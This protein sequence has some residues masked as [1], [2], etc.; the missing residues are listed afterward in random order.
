MAFKSG[1]I[2][3]RFYN[4]LGL[5]FILIFFGSAGFVY[6]AD[7]G[8]VNALYMTVITISTVGFKEVEP[9]DAESKIFTIFLIITSITLFGYI[10]SVITDY[11]ANNKFIEELKFKQVQKKIHRL[12]NHTIVCGFG[13][14]GKQA[15]ARLK[16]YKQNCV[17]VESDPELIEDIERDGEMLY[18]RGDATSDEVLLSA[19]I[20]RASSLITTLPSD[21]DNLYVVLSA[22]QLN[23]NCTIVSRASVDTSNRKLK[24]A[25]ADNVIMPDKIGGAHMASLVITPDVIE[26]IDRLSIEGESSSNIEE[27]V[28]ENLPEKYT[29]KSIL[30]LDLRKRTGCTVIGFKTPDKEYIINPDAT[31]ILVPKSKLIV[32]GRPEEIQKLNKLF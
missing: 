6:I 3:S 21:A 7:Y 17:I 30:D 5:L 19:G 20:E 31:T 26:F 28:I 12:E 22:R 9:L 23:D 18:I 27:L 15:M 25:G 8:W 13:R 32:I 4:A 24:V 2:K 10:I 16:S 1:F 14:N 29:N 11:I